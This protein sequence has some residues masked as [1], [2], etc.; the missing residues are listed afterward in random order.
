MVVAVISPKTTTRMDLEIAAM[1]CDVLADEGLKAYSV[2]DG[3][4]RCLDADVALLVGDC[5]EFDQTADLLRDSTRRRP[6]TVLWQLHALPPPDLPES[7]ASSGL[8]V[9][10]ALHRVQSKGKLGR[11]LV[12]LR[13]YIPPNLRVAVRSLLYA[14]VRRAASRNTGLSEWQLDEASRQFML[15]RFAWFQRR[16]AEGGLDTLSMSTAP[17][18]AFLQAHGIS[19]EWV[20]FG[21]HR[22]FSSDRRATRDIDVLFLGRARIRRRQTLLEQI[23]TALDGQG[24]RFHVVER[25][26]FGETRIKTLNRTRISLNLTNYPWEVP[27]IRFLMSM[28]CGALVVSERLG[29]S[30][31]FRDGEHFVS[32]PA[33][34]LPDVILRLLADDTERRRITDTAW[35]YV[36]ERLTLRHSVT[37]LV[38]LTRTAV[39][40][41]LG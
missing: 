7:V 39:E 31:P 13:G 38:D 11:A 22:S 40:A 6:R 14:G 33:E 3:D 32:A 24:R 27:G 2:A 10:D 23:E 28:A 37:R 4:E 21:Y 8:R 12:G 41:P 25:G 26:C 19:A 36:T 5:L 17:R 29:N 9:A 35:R 30:S 1:V 34:Q 16:V 20:P 15:M 18:V